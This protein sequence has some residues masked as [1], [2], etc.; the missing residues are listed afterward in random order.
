[1]LAK[2]IAGD[3]FCL[4]LFEG[5]LADDN[6]A[7]IHITSTKSD[8]PRALSIV[9]RCT[10]AIAMHGRHDDGDPDTIWLGGLHWGQA[11]RSEVGLRNQIQAWKNVAKDNN[12]KPKEIWPVLPG[13]GVV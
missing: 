13:G 4:Y 8:E 10:T 3:D 5:I 11:I 1:M 6:F 9:G 2:E 7:E 12:S